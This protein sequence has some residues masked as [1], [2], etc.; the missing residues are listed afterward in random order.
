M[1]NLMARW[2]ITAVLLATACATPDRKSDFE[3]TYVPP[4]SAGSSGKSNDQGQ[5]LLNT[6]PPGKVSE[7]EEGV[8]LTGSLRCTG[9][10]GKT[11]VQGDVGFDA[12]VAKKKEQGNTPESGVSVEKK[13]GD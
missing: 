3:P 8:S 11:L 7:T 9:A 10:D 12:C 1:I 2:M 6:K 13:F 4:S 5:V